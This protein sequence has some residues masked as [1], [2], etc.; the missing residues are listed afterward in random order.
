MNIA[1]IPLEKDEKIL[2]INKCTKNLEEGHIREIFNQF[3]KVLDVKR[4][5]K[6][7]SGMKDHF[8]FVKFEDWKGM[9]KAYC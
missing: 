1:T 4:A 6:P 3:G 9:E 7:D 8:I 5:I 2:K